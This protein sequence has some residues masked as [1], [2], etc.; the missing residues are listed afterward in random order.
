MILGR[1]DTTPADNVRPHRGLVEVGK[2]QNNLLGFKSPISA[3]AAEPNGRSQN[4]FVN[5]HGHIINLSI[6]LINLRIMPKDSVA[7]GCPDPCFVEHGQ[8]YVCNVPNLGAGR[9]RL[10]TRAMGG[11]EFG[12]RDEGVSKLTQM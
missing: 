9:Y 10:K 8:V 12:A 7:P 6:Y 1:I 5:C 4:F 11:G 2:P 3:F